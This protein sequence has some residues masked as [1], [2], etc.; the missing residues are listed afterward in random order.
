MPACEIVVTEDFRVTVSKKHDD[1]RQDIL[2]QE[3]V[4][5]RTLAAALGL[6]QRYPGA[7]LPNGHIDFELSAFGGA[8][9]TCQDCA[10]VTALLHEATEDARRLGVVYG[11]A[12]PP[13]RPR[14][15]SA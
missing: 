4:A 8:I 5:F 13:P 7:R 3:E 2:Y 6:F 12:M 11:V 15:Q 10:M 1:E 14:S 9:L